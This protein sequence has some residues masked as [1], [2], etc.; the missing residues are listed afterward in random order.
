MEEKEKISL[1]QL[2]QRLKMA[3]DNA[4]AGLVWITAE[5]GEVKGNSTGHWYLELVDYDQDGKTVTAK[6]R[7]TIWSRTAAMLIPYFTSTAGASLSA[8]MRVL[9]KVQVQYSVV[10]GLSLNILDIDPSYTIGELELERQRVIRRLQQEGMFDINGQLP[11]TT[12]PKRLAIVSSPT[13]AGYRDFMKHISFEES[14]VNID[15]QLFSASM[16][17]GD[18]PKSIISALEKV[19]GEL[20]GSGNFDAVVIVRG[21]GSALELACYDDY[22]L[23]LNIAQFPL[24]V[25]VGVGHDHD[26][27][28]ADMVAHTS[29]KTPTA[30]A[31]FIIGL[32]MEQEARL[33]A[34]CQRCRMAV[35]AKIVLQESIL[36]RLADRLKNSWRTMV[37]DRENKLKFVELK[38]GALDPG[39]LL[40][41]GYMLAQLESGRRVV[42]VNDLPDSGKI[43][44]FMGD[45]V[46]DLDI[47]VR[48]RRRD[49]DKCQK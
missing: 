35:T 4:V 30:V 7:A 9:L 15:T 16:Q 1:G 3:V 13:A 23:A 43:R 36:A 27:H 24:P 18:A 10:Y 31:D 17:G 40:E 45:G 26:F 21:G 46:V 22:D 5:I 49:G 47:V 19:V 37:M 11:L 8:G 41:R 48:S 32:Y 33:D 6:A 14:G 2:Q 42:S 20:S 34:L 39:V 38:M 44:L 12:L 29:C 28:V 25:I